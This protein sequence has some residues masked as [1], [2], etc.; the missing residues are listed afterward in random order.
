MNIINNIKSTVLRRPI[1]LRVIAAVIAFA[2]IIWLL[3]GIN[4]LL[5]NPISYYLAKTNSEK[6]VAEKYGD[7]GYVV[8]DIGYS[9]KFKNYLVL[10]EKPGSKDCYFTVYCGMDGKPDAD[11]YDSYVA[12]GGNTRR[13]L[14]ESYRKLADSIFE[15]PSFPY[16]S[17]ISGGSLV[18]KGDGDKPD[19]YDFGLSESILVPD[20][21]YDIEKLGKQAGLLTVYIDTE[22]LTAEFAS[23][24]LLRIKALANLGM[25]PFYAIELTLENSAHEYYPV[26]VFR[27]ADIYEEGLVERVKVSHQKKEELNA[28]EDKKKLG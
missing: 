15:S 6:Y 7:E 26:G 4:D 19:E 1:P 21:E 3:F 16:S 9:F 28:I 20:A 22:N 8:S 11:N 12:G 24:A 5:G 27:S 18:F 25:V 13:R 23:E 14:E 2:I 17:K 10:A